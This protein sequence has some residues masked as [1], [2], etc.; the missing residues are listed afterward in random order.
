VPTTPGAL[1]RRR[2]NGLPAKTKHPST[3]SILLIVLLLLIVVLL[4]LAVGLLVYWQ[5]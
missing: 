4:L 3:V 2:A 1:S 5:A